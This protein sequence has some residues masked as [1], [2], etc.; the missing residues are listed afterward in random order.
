MNDYGDT[1]DAFLM[2][3]CERLGKK[4][5]VKVAG[6]TVHFVNE[7]MDTGPVILQAAV[8]VLED[9][10]PETLHARIQI[11]EHRLYPQAIR[12]F[13][14]GKLRIEGRHVRIEN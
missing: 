8:P 13:A 7:G 11:E 14:L 1:Y 5:G 4:Y 10:T 3:T 12:L 6:C 9:D 2:L